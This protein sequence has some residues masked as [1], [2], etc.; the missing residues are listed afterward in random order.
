MLMMLKPFKDMTLMEQKKNNFDRS[1]VSTLW[2]F[3]Y[4]LSKLEAWE[5]VAKRNETGFRSAVNLCW[6]L[7]KKYYIKTDKCPVYVVA[8]VLDPRY[9]FLYFERH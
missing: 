1:I 4:L 6:T 7:I 5:S 2:A 8:Q 9:K 3:D